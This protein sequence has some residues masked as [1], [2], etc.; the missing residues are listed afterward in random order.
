MSVKILVTDRN[1]RPLANAK[2][3]V[4]WERSTSTEYT[5]GTG[6]ADLRC[7]GGVIEQIQVNNYKVHQGRIRVNDNATVPV[8]LNR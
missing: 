6:I 8:Q 4:K 2:V 3:F 7:S 5:N 1:E